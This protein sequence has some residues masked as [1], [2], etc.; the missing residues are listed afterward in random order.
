MK[1][2][3][4]FLINMYRS[5]FKNSSITVKSVETL[6]KWDG[7]FPF[8]SKCLKYISTTMKSTKT[9]TKVEGNFPYKYVYTSKI[10]PLRLNLLK[11]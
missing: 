1:M 3:L 8:I 4:T 2:I 11:P 7:N 10:F 6:T 9:L 5:F